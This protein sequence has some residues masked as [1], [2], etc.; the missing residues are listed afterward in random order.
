MEYYLVFKL[1]SVETRVVLMNHDMDKVKAEWGA[2][3]GLLCTPSHPA[4]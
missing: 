1:R 3:L 2:N 4:L